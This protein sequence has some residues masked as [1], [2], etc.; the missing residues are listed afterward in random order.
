MAYKGKRINP[1]KFEMSQLKIILVILPLVIFM[2]LPIIFII[3]HAFKPMEELFAFPPTFFV[4]N[5]T[6]ENFT[7]LMKFSNSNGI[8]LSRYVF[9]SLIVTVLTVG[10]SL[11]LTTLIIE[12]PFLQSAF[13][14]TQ[15]GWE[16]YVI[17]MGLAILVIPIVETVKFFQRLAAKK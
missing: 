2:A 13:S 12:V 8:P 3:N 9:N 16:E 15:I 17:S 4:K 7:K 5:A 11:L 10:L 1:R 14:F 6:F